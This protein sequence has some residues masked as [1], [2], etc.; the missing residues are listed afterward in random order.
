MQVYCGLVKAEGFAK[1]L[2]IIFSIISMAFLLLVMLIVLSR[3]LLGMNIRGLFSK[4]VIYVLTIVSFF[5]QVIG[6]CCLNLF[7]DVTY[8]AKKEDCK[9]NFAASRMSI[10]AEDG[11]YMAF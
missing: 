8:A 2:Y 9:S 6:A 7:L 11:F 3:H 10:C 1:T 5:F 4:K